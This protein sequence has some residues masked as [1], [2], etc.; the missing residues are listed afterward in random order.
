[1][2]TCHKPTH[3]LLEKIIFRVLSIARSL[4]EEKYRDDDPVWELRETL[5]SHHSF[6]QLFK[7]SYYP[8][9]TAKVCFNHSTKS[10]TQ[11]TAMADSEL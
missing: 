4:S 2:V 6:G 11:D 3:F 5:L 7:E 9:G 8:L 1:M 10:H